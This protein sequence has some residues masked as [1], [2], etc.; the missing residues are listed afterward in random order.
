MDTQVVSYPREIPNNSF[1]FDPIGAA[2]TY[3]YEPAQ[4]LATVRNIRD[5]LGFDPVIPK[6]LPFGFELQRSELRQNEDGQLAVLWVTDGLA[7]ARVY[8]FRCPT[9]REGMWSLGT[10]TVLTENGVT[11][12]M[13]SDLDTSVRQAI[14]H[15]FARREPNQIS[16][17]KQAS[18]VYIGVKKTPIPGR[19]PAS[20]QQM[21][22]LP[23]PAIGIG[24]PPQVGVPPPPAPVPGQI[25][26]IKGE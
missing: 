23:E 14:M 1:R 21:F 19:E 18:S 6:R 20:P 8:Q 15:A 25:T 13:V 26:Q 17:P 11:M 12:M 24:S 3:R 4:A 5:R 9:L 7:T 2:R 16:P 10:S 22:S